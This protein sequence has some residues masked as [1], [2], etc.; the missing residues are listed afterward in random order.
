MFIVNIGE[1]RAALAS[2][3]DSDPVWIAAFGS[4]GTIRSVA[5]HAGEVYVIPVGLGDLFAAAEEAQGAGENLRGE[6]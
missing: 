3:Q 2:F 4:K 1:L 6:R 5:V